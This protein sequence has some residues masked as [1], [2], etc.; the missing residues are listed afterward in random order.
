MTTGEQITTITFFRYAS[1]WKRL[2]AFGMMNYAHERLKEVQGLQ[3]YKLLGIGRDGGFSPLPDWSAYGLLQTWQSELDAIQ[4]FKNS[5]LMT[6]YRKKAVEIWTV[7]LKNITGKGTWSGEEP[8]EPNSSLDPEN[9]LLAVITRA[10]IFKRKLWAFWKYVPTSHLPLKHNQG[11]LFS[12]GIGEVPI[13]QNATFTLWEN[14]EA[15]QAYAYKSPEHLEAMRRTRQQG[16]YKE[17]LFTRFQPYRSE[18]TWRGQE[19]LK[20]LQPAA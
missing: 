13:L 12:K 18:G 20:G 19:L 3:F 5:S 15:L 17:E 4:F 16:W 8:F 10:T 1:F 14:Q 2:W 9:A 7:Y 6:D 11:L